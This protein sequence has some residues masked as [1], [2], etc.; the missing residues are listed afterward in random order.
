M[1]LHVAC[2][3]CS[4]RHWGQQLQKHPTG[5]TASACIAAV[6]CGQLRRSTQIRMLKTPTSMAA[7]YT[8]HAMQFILLSS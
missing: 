5:A 2:P 6:V 3:N 8:V 4:N 7:S 1:E